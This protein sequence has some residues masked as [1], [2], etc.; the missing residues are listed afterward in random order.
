MQKTLP[1]IGLIAV[2]LLAGCMGVGLDKTEYSA[3]PAVVSN[4]TAEDTGYTLQSTE[5]FEFNET[6]EMNNEE[7]RI[8]ANNWISMYE[9]SE[10][11]ELPGSNQTT[12]VMSIFGVISTPSL[13][14]VGQEMNPLVRTPTDEV[15]T[16]VTEENERITVKDKVGEETVKHAE[17]GQNITVEKYDS[18]FNIGESN[19]TVDGYILISV[20]SHEDAVIVTVGVYPD[21]YDQEEAIKEMIQNVEVVEEAPDGEAE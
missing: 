18:E 5:Q 10:G 13:E 1:L 14:F 7:Y 2:L 15:I 20:F 16:R 21:Q 6:V 11:V 9:K 4:D 12:Q 8:T 17:T 19:Q 3:P